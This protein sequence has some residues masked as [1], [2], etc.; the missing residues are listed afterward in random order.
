MVFA[1][2]L[3]K[4]D[5]F[6]HRGAQSGP[7]GR[8]HIGVGLKAALADVGTDGGVD[9]GRIAAVFGRHGIHGLFDDPRGGAPPPGMD[10]AHGAGDRIP[11]EDGGAVGSE[12]H[13]ARARLIGD[14]GVAFWIFMVVQ[15]DVVGP[16]DFSDDVG[17]G[18]MAQD[19]LLEGKTDALTQDPVVFRHI[20]IRIAPVHGDIQAAPDALADAGEPGGKAMGNLDAVGLQIFHIA[21]AF[22]F[23]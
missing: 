8:G 11:Q 23:D 21:V 14:E 15:A 1:G 20:F 17:M 7:E 16:A 12:D 13:Q 18:L 9:I 22:V 4:F 3:V 5:G 6:L 19:Q 10:R 2:I